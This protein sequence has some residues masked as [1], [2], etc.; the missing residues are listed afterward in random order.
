MTTTI[1][2]GSLIMFGG[3]IEEERLSDLRDQGW[4]LCDG[5][6]YPARWEYQALSVRIGTSYGSGGGR[7]NVPDFRGRFARGTDHGRGQDPDTSARVALSPG[8]NTGDKVGSAQPSATGLPVTPFRADENLTGHQHQALYVPT[9]GGSTGGAPDGAPKG[10]DWPGDATQTSEGGDHPHAL[11]GYD[12]E[13]R[14]GNVYAHY[15]IKFRHVEPAD[16]DPQAI[17]VGMVLPFA[18]D[19]ADPAVAGQLRLEGWLPC[20]GQLLKPAGYQGLF[21]V[22]R[23]SFGGTGDGFSLPDL[24]GQFVRGARAAARPGPGETIGTGQGYATMLP[25]RG[26]ASPLEATPGGAHIHKLPSSDGGYFLS[27]YGGSG[28]KAASFNQ[29]SFTVGPAGRHRHAISGGDRESRPVNIYVD[30]IIKFAE[31]AS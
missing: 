31:P 13:T 7:F 15:F 10:M 25:R 12:A 4:L 5:A 24:R 21:D 26:T 20:F 18:G 17:P 6:P 14:P 27:N 2:I 3:A 28:P 19:A 8:G 22:V 9:G 30:Y 11:A 29:G 16:P 1:P 23:Y